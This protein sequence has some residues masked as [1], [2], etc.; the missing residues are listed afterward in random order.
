M[1]KNGVLQPRKNLI[2]TTLINKVTDTLQEKQDNLEIPEN[3]EQ[4]KEFW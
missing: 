2:L 4:L 1:I 3:Q